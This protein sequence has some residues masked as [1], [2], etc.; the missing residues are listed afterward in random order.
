M[1]DSGRRCGS[2]THERA[3]VGQQ[4]AGVTLNNDADDLVLLF[5]LSQVSALFFFK[6]EQRERD[7]SRRQVRRIIERESSARSHGVTSKERATKK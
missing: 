7:T 1:A 6:K 3:A 2:S 5:F 4:S